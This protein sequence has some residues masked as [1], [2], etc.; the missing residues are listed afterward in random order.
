MAHIVFVDANLTA[1]DAMARA[2]E[3]GHET[4]FVERAR[5]SLTVYDLSDKRDAIVRSMIAHEWIH[6]DPS[7]EDFDLAFKNINN[8]RQIDA[9]VCTMDACMVGCAEMAKIYQVPFISPEAAVLTRNK[10]AVRKKLDKLS[11]TN[12]QHAEVRSIDDA[13]NFARGIGYPVIIKPSGGANSY[14]SFKVEGDDHL[15]QVWR[16]IQAELEPM[17]GAVRKQLGEGYVI[18]EYLIGKMVSVEIL[19]ADFSP[20]ILMVSERGRSKHDELREFSV[21]MPADISACDWQACADYTKKLITGLD[22]RVGI[23]HIELI[24][25]EDR[26]PVLVEVNLV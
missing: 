22:L 21:T 6:I 9:I 2:N 26:G 13:L 19:A 20:E 7:R 12:A 5:S 3:L 15:E 23:F 1:F 24:L 8:V 10:G 17:P 11:L 18:E 16:T 25:T 14:L 4:S